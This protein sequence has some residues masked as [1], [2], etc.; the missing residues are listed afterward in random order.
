MTVS[1]LDTRQINANPFLR[2]SSAKRETECFALGAKFPGFHLR[3]HNHPGELFEPFG[4]YQR[5]PRNIPRPLEGSHT[6]IKPLTG[7]RRG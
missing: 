7:R 1:R 3:F 4:A 5:L 6:I 2:L